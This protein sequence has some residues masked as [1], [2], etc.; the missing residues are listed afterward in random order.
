MATTT[1]LSALGKLDQDWQAGERM[2][3]GTFALERELECYAGPNLIGGPYRDDAR[4]GRACGA[5]HEVVVRAVLGGRTIAEWTLTAGPKRFTIAN[6]PPSGLTHEALR[7]A[8]FVVHFP[9][10][11]FDRVS[12]Q[13]RGRY[14]PSTTREMSRRSG[15]VVALPYEDDGGVIL[16]GTETWKFNRPEARKVNARVGDR[17]SFVG[18]LIGGTN[19]ATDLKVIASSRRAA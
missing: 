8:K 11:D 17:V 3:A 6:P 19:V 9:W 13:L 7:A 4:V 16:S 2:Y 15:E 10:R 18:R 12:A 5:L 14:G 1:Q